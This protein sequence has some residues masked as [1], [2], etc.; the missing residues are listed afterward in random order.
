M[1]HAKRP[2]E[3]PQA[4]AQPEAQ[5]GSESASRTGPVYPV[6]VDNRS[7]RSDKDA[8]EGGHVKVVSGEHEGAKGVFQSVA[9]YGDDGYPKTIVVNFTDVAYTAQSAAVP[10]ADV[11]PAAYLE[12]DDEAAQYAAEQA[13]ARVMQMQ[14]DEPAQQL[15]SDEQRPAD[16]PEQQRIES[17]GPQPASEGSPG[18]K[19][20]GRTSPSIR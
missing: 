6:R 13:E 12:P 5:S 10:Y 20:A 11:V 1:P 2:E 8:Y 16:R 3:A 19:S 9:E 15:A 7:A 18:E 14:P 4:Q 17:G